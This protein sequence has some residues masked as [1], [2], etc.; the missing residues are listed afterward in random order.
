MHVSAPV[1][2]NCLNCNKQMRYTRT[3]RGSDGSQDLDVFECE[4]CR[5]SEAL[6][7]IATP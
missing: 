2:P 4:A 6:P 5:I 3:A 1:G 7:T